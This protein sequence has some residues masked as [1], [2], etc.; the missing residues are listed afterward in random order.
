MSRDHTTT[1][2]RYQVEA[3]GH[4]HESRC[5]SLKEARTIAKLLKSKGCTKVQIA[6]YDTSDKSDYY[7]IVEVL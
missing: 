5:Y 7:E 1:A 3:N 6:R 2:M 4:V